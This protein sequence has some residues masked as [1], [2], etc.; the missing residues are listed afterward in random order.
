MIADKLP[1]DQLFSLQLDFPPLSA[2]QEERIEMI[3]LALQEQIG[4]Q[5]TNSHYANFEPPPTTSIPQSSRANLE[6]GR[7]EEEVTGMGGTSRSREGVL[8]SNGSTGGVNEE[9]D[10][11]F[12]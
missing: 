3:R 4:V 7:E 5:A 2:K 12:L 6:E 9:E 1:L 10:G 8:S 11:L